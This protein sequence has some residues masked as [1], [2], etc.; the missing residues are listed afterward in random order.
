VTARES[1]DDMIRS[2]IA[3]ELKATGFKRA[4]NRFVRW[5]GDGWQIID[6]QASQWGDRDA[7]RFTINLATAV[8]G[9]P[10][11]SAW[12]DKKPPP[13]Y[14]AHLRQ[15]IGGLLDGTDHW[16]DFGRGTDPEALGD[17]I[18]STVRRVGLPWLAT[19]S[20]MRQVLDLIAREPDALGWH[21]LRALP[22]LL[23]DSGHLDAAK[24][25]EAE[26]ARRGSP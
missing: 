10:K 7:V 16:W 26:A 23:A 14:A 2:V 11:R 5:E 21:D 4:R 17:E 13:E 18:L 25:V 9:L 19:R 3:P 20:G 24:A 15:R 6:F 22:K 1:Y 8:D 12:D